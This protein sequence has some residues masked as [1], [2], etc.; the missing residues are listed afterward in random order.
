MASQSRK[1]KLC[2]VVGGCGFLGRHLA[3]GLLA[4]GYEVQ[5]FDLRKTFD[6]DRIR[7]FTGDLCK[8]EDL[9]PALASVSVVFHVASPAPS[10]NNRKLFYR[11]NVDGTK[12]LIEACKEAGVT[13]L[14]LTSSASVVYSGYDIENGSEDLP[15][16]SSPI[17]Y[18]TETKIL[19]EKIVLGANS[20]G[21]DEEFLTVAIRPHGIFGPRDPQCIPTIV[22]TARTGKM[23]FIIGNGQNMVDFTYVENVVHGHI[24]AAEE[25]R[26][27]SL[28]CGKA[29]H[30]TN[31]AP[32]PFWKFMGQVVKAVELPEP[33]VRLPY[34]L[35]YGL[36]VILH[37]VCVALSPIVT[38]TPTFTPM[39]VA[40]AGT[41]HY[42]SCQRAKTELGYSPVVKMDEGLKRSMEDFKRRE[43]PRW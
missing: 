11:V 39:R 28:V 22:R 38:I 37:Y 20:V 2:T 19:Q 26:A 18:Y 7:F 42:Y 1:K 34:W 12:N 13:R 21:A 23:K 31:D 33:Q 43:Q 25:L 35:I 14:V 8:K 40:L 24:L 32:L 29:Y 36:A 5:V 41:H 10:S 27:D 4:K 15:Y 17:D 6:D 30:I 16:A 9:L 3:E